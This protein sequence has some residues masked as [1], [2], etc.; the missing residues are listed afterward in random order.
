MINRKSGHERHLINI[1]HCLK[2]FQ[3]KIPAEAGT[4]QAETFQGLDFPPC[5]DC[6]GA[7]SGGCSEAQQGEE[8]KQ[9]P[10]EP[11]VTY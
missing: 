2:H 5:L 3:S 4:A 11:Q 8:I 1:S 7:S 10:R 6:S 9:T